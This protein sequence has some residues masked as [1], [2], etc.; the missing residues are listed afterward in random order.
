MPATGTGGYHPH[1][2]P[3]T[4]L[5]P[6]GAAGARR[7]VRGP[8]VPRHL[9]RRRAWRRTS[10]TAASRSDEHLAHAAHEVP[11]WVKLTPLGRDADRPRDRLEQ[12][13]PPARAPRARS[14]RQFPAVHRFVL[15]KWYFDE[16]YDCI[17]VRP[18]L[19]LGRLVLAARR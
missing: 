16:L 3:L 4:M 17:F 10:G 12:L 2:S 7:D 1:E 15:N 8:A 11:L 19:W 6:L 13:H 9:R 5:V 18:A 14:S